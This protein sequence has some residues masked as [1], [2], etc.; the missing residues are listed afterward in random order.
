MVEAAEP[1]ATEGLPKSR[2]KKKRQGKL[3]KD[4]YDDSSTFSSEEEPGFEDNEDPVPDGA[5]KTNIPAKKKPKTLRHILAG[6]QEPKR[7]DPFCSSSSSGP[8]ESDSEDEGFGP[9]KRKA[10]ISI[11]A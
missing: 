9:K 2:A 8:E 4:N 1:S 7:D 5:T 6:K 10:K 11:L 3:K